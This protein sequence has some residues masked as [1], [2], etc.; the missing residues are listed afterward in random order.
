M[1]PMAPHPA[2]GEGPTDSEV[3]AWSLQAMKEAGE[4]SSRHV[5]ET[6]E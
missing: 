6:K 5:G 2:L 3:A 1:A 4:V